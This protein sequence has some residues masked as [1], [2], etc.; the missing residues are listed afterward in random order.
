[1]ARLTTSDKE[2]M[3]PELPPLAFTARTF[4][5]TGSV[6]IGAKF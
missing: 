6:A 1:L 5:A 2:L 4:G 3:T